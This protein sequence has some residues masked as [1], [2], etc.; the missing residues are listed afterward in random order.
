MTQEMEFMSKF[1]MQKEIDKLKKREKE[2]ADSNKS[3]NHS[4]NNEINRR[5]KLNE[6]NRELKDKI[7]DL[8]DNKVLEQVN[9]SA[10]EFVEKK[11]QK[12]DHLCHQC[13]EG[14]YFYDIHKDK[15]NNIICPQCFN[16]NKG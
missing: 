4:L 5:K 2:L 13:S 8:S 3:L 1:E 7:N 15:D 16:K 11:N 10:K 14:L 9:K 6:E 12:H